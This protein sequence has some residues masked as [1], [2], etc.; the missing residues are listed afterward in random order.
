MGKIARKIRNSTAATATFSVS[1]GDG[2]IDE[3]VDT[4]YQWYIGEL[5]K[6]EDNSQYLYETK[7]PQNKAERSNGSNER[8]YD[9]TELPTN[10]TS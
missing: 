4:A 10:S 9:G 7:I 6:L 5:W 2:A 1:P 3:F 8:G